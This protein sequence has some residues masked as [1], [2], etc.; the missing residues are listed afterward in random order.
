M[1][2][3]AAPR[4]SASTKPSTTKPILYVRPEARTDLAKYY[5][6]AWAAL[7]L[8]FTLAPWSDAG[9]DGK[10]ADDIAAFL[11]GV[12][13]SSD[14]DCEYYPV[15]LDGVD[16][17][18]AAFFTALGIG[19]KERAS[20]GGYDNPKLEVSKKKKTLQLLT[21]LGDDEFEELD[22]YVEEAE[23]R[24]LGKAAKAL[25]AI[26]PPVGVQL[27]ADDGASKVV[28][29]LAAVGP[30]RNLGILAVRIET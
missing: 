3:K 24:A 6:G 4:T 30:S 18:S 25:E 10:R 23:Q 14:T 17:A 8:R 22:E 28:M 29:T 27:C 11:E 13:H 2:K 26:A 7:E 15:V 12:V 21:R 1:T 9:K 19:A 20:V 16:P 5:A